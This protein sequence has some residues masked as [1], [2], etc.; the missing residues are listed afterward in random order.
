MRTMRTRVED[1]TFALNLA[2]FLDIIVSI[3]PMLLLSIAFVQI[4][5]INAPTPQIVSKSEIKHAPKPQTTISLQ[6]SKAH[7]FVFEVTSPSGHVQRMAIANKN[8]HF[9]LKGLLSSAIAIK[10]EH[11]KVTQL[12]LMPQGDVA[13]NDLVHIM[14]EVRERPRPQA[15]AS[16]GDTPIPV[17]SSAYELFPNVTFGNVGG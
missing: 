13:F 6:I 7:G 10:K 15:K 4:R 1:S 8:G 9:D 17:D 12:Q 5:M 3:V 14:D 11:P 16:F 2:P